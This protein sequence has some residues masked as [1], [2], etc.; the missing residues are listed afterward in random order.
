MIILRPTE[1]GGL[2]GAS[3]TIKGSGVDGLG[4]C[5]RMISGGA[6]GVNKLG[7]FV[8]T[9]FFN[10]VKLRQK[11]KTNQ[12]SKYQLIFIYTISPGAGGVGGLR[13]LTANSCTYSSCCF[14]FLVIT[15]GFESSLRLIEKRLK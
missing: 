14:T 13:Y 15:C 4:G 2:G 9:L 7:V 3:L 8:M 6:G 5:W 11:I 12:L 10:F 1:F